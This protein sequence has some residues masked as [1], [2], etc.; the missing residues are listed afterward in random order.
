MCYPDILINI[1]T[2]VRIFD[3]SNWSNMEVSY[4]Q[5]DNLQTNQQRIFSDS[6]MNFVYPEFFKKSCDQKNNNYSTF[7]LTS[8]LNFENCF[9]LSNP[10]QNGNGFVT[11]FSSG[12]NTIKDSAQRYWAI[13]ESASSQKFLEVSTNIFFAAKDSNYY[14]EI[15]FLPNNKCRISHDYYNTKYYLNV[16][17]LTNKAY[18]LSASPNLFDE[19]SIYKQ[20]F[21]YILDETNNNMLFFTEKI[22]THIL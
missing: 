6:C 17:F 4:F 10:E 21:E 9:S 3:E 19:E 7:A 15:D 11:F 8:S 12:V 5:D 2:P 16:N 1:F 13:L 22:I 20:S 14:F 18:F